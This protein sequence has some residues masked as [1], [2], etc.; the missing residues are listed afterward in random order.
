[1]WLETE[2]LSR[3]YWTVAKTGMVTG[4]WERRQMLQAIWTEQRWWE[5]GQQGSHQ[6]QLQ[7]CALFQTPAALR[8]AGGGPTFK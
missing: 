8:T 5:G 2:V 7:G 3:W 1:M 6:G 4:D